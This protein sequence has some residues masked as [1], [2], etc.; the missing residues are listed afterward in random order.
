MLRLFCWVL[1]CVICVLRSRGAIAIWVGGLTA[2]AGVLPWCGKDVVDMVAGWL[3]GCGCGEGGASVNVEVWRFTGVEC[4]GL[5]SGTNQVDR[6]F[7]GCQHGVELIE[8]VLYGES[9]G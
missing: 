4:L 2:A 1:C 8:F 7:R 9:Y 5:G 6:D 3:V